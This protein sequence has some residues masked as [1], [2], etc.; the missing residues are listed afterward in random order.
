MTISLLVA[1]L[2][3]QDTVDNPEYRGW[4]AFKPGSSVT[5]KIYQDGADRDMAQ[6][7]TLK[8]FDERQAVVETE[9]TMMGKPLGKATVR[10][11]AAKVAA[12]DEP[13]RT[14]EGEE[15]IDV[16]GKKLKCKCFE[17]E[18]AGAGGKKMTLKFWVN[19]DVPGM[20]VRCDVTTEGAATKGVMVATGWEKK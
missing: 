15:E 18:K 14:K 13:K 17:I 11:I 6:K 16:A 7:M 3:A 12:A 5:F 20:A 10:R 4:A 1:L 19:D 9:M 8:S 2:L